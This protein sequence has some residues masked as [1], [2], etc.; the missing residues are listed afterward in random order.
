[1]LY[2]Q[3]KLSLKG[4]ILIFQRF[5]NAVQMF[6]SQKMF[7]GSAFQTKGGEE[8][9][10]Q[11]IFFFFYGLQASFQW[12]ERFLTSYF[13]KSSP[14]LGRYWIIHDVEATVIS[15][16]S[17]WAVCCKL[18]ADSFEI[19]FL[20]FQHAESDIQTRLKGTGS[21]QRSHITPTFR[22]LLFI[23]E[24]TGIALYD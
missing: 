13:V 15:G 21:D 5:K 1:M 9:E 12:S 11:V 14:T 24:S 3:K 6:W 10:R 7:V 17:T 23:S 20:G 19:S 8:E 18:V 16:N 4:F 22:F 2:Q